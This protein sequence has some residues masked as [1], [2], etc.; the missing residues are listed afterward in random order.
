MRQLETLD[1]VETLPEAIRQDEAMRGLAYA[2]QRQFRKLAQ[3]VDSGALFTNIDT[4]T[5]LQ[6]D[7]LAVMFD[8]QTWRDYWPVSLKRSVMK[9]AFVNKRKVG[10]L[11]AVREAL[12]SIGSASRVIEWWQETPKATPHTFKIA[13][14]LKDIE[15]T[16]TEQMQEDLQ[17]MIRNA[18]PA[19]SHYEFVLETTQKGGIG[20][21][22]YARSLVDARISNF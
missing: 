2:F 14:T 12:E 20:L 16:L 13:A 1:L 9:S 10:T 19:R 5:S 21:C 11:A 17:I 7:H 8:L 18:K 3:V 22:G 6:L 4:M 15:G